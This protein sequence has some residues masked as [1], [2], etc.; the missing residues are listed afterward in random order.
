MTYNTH[1]SHGG[2]NPKPTRP[3]TTQETHAHTD[4]T[5]D[6]SIG[7]PFAVNGDPSGGAKGSEEPRSGGG[8]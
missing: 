2:S 8:T 3:K 7:S 4:Y 1:G 5:K 6:R